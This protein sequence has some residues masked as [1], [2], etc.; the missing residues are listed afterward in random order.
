[1]KWNHIK[2]LNDNSYDSLVARVGNGKYIYDHS[3]INSLVNKWNIYQPLLISEQKSNHFIPVL[4]TKE[5]SERAHRSFILRYRF[6]FIYLLFFLAAF[7]IFHFFDNSDRSLKVLYISFILILYFFIDFKLKTENINIL[8]E[9]A[10]FYT[11]I[12]LSGRK[13]FIIWAGIMLSSAVIQLSLNYY[14]NDFEIPIYKFGA[15]YELIDHGEYWRLITGSY[16]HTSFQHWVINT[17]MIVLIAPIACCILRGGCIPIFI[18]ANVFSC[19]GAY[20]IYK[21]NFTEASAFAGVSGGLFSF[22]GLICCFSILNKNKVPQ[23]MFLSTF[24]FFVLNL[25]LSFILVPDISNTSHIVGFIV[26]FLLPLI[27]RGK[28]LHIQK[29]F[30]FF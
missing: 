16:F 5:F 1:M 7:G 21:L 6:I 25:I 22:L 14:F 28:R 15:V 30:L 26:G 19:T 29:R 18:I 20:L 8:K 11:W 17:L 13:Y 2:L 4:E 24:L 27:F 12:N 10:S 23:N 9:H 3:K